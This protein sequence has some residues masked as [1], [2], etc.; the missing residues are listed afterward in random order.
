MEGLAQDAAPPNAGIGKWL[1]YWTPAFTT[2][3]RHRGWIVGR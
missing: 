1:V 2:G 3:G